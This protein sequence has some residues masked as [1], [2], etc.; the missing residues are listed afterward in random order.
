MAS[1]DAL[2]LII[3]TPSYWAPSVGRSVSEESS[4]NKNERR[5]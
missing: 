3:S 4:T 5:F 1:G 2:S